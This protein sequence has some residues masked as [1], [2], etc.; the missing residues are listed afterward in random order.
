M[1]GGSV[2]VE[3]GE[4]VS[5]SVNTNITDDTCLCVCV[6]SFVSVNSLS[7]STCYWIRR[8]GRDQSRGGRGAARKE[9]ESREPVT[10][11]ALDDDMDSYMAAR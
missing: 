10:Q 11:D 4:S 2:A 7:G 1:Q 5:Q 6:H 8:G 3:K 9:R